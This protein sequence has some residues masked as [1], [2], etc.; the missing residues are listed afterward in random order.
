M[1]RFS[2]FV[3]LAT[4]AAFAVGCGK[5]NSS[6]GG[7]RYGSLISDNSQLSSDSLSAA[8]NFKRWMDTTIV[9]NTYGNFAIYYN[10]ANNAGSNPNCEEK[11]FLGIPFY[12]C[13]GYSNSGG[14]TGDGCKVSVFGGTQQT[15][16]NKLQGN[17]TLNK[18]YNASSNGL[19]LVNASQ[20]NTSNWQ[21]NVYRLTFQKGDGSLTTYT[22]DT[23]YPASFQPMAVSED[24]GSYK[25]VTGIYTSAQVGSTFSS[26]PTCGSL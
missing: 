25:V 5:D 26:L 20:S 1:K 11:E 23:Q 9:N 3:I 6:G 16:Q 17:A 14:S 15:L 10:S 21:N 18:I 12:F 13:S 24:D 7:N 2:K 19:V 8:G 22:I 4:L